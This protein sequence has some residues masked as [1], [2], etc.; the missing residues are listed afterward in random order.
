MSKIDA[1][2]IHE[3]LRKQLENFKPEIDVREVGTVIQVG[4]GI[5]RCDGLKG[6]MAG[7]LLEFVGSGGRTVFGMALNL[8]EHEV[9]AVLMG[10]VTAI[11][12]NDTV[13]TT[14]R[15]VQVPSGKALLGRIVNPLGEPIDGKGPIQAEGY[16]PVEF[17]APGVIERKPVH[18]PI[19]RK[20]VV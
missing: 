19:D 13:R 14:G 8:D 20:S 11:R 18:E 1:Q 4:D 3:V 16:R 17:R 5:A 6:A 7:E 15:I 2:A 9:G 10:E 12:E